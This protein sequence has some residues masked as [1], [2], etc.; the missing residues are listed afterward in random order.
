MNQQRSKQK[1]TAPHFNG[2]NILLWYQ[3][4]ACKKSLKV[5]VDKLMKIYM[6]NFDYFKM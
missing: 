3:N 6:A 2:N 4:K 5:N 1:I